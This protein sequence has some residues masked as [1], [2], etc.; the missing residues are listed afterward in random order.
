MSVSPIVMALRQAGTPAA[1]DPETWTRWLD[2]CQNEGLISPRTRNWLGV[3]GWLSRQVGEVPARSLSE[4]VRGQET[5]LRVVD[6]LAKQ[7]HTEHRHLVGSHEASTLIL[8]APLDLSGMKGLVLDQVC[9]V[10]GYRGWSTYLTP[11]QVAHAT[12]CH[13][14]QEY[15]PGQG[16]AIRPETYK[17]YG[18]DL[19]N[20]LIEIKLA[21]VKDAGGETVALVSSV[22]S[23]WCREGRLLGYTADWAPGHDRVPEAPMKNVHDWV[24]RAMKQAAVWAAERGAT[25]VAW[26]DGMQKCRLNLQAFEGCMLR[27]NRKDDQSFNYQVLRGD[28]WPLMHGQVQLG[29][30]LMKL[31]SVAAEKLRDAP[32]GES[33]YEDIEV[34]MQGDETN[35]VHDLVLPSVMR[36]WAASYDADLRAGEITVR[37]F[38]VVRTFDAKRERI[39]SHLDENEAC[40]RVHAHGSPEI[41]LEPANI[42]YRAYSFALTPSMKLAIEENYDVP[43]QPTDVRVVGMGR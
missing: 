29:H 38:D 19:P 26:I 20:A 25:R 16:P 37:S 5:P 34:S 28:G 7:S 6:L 40:Q 1:G 13:Q 43:D 32:L 31:G 23:P 8:M 10:L 22:D 21:L 3:D 14:A 27:I 33:S 2:A 30:A 4:F 17:P 9:K 24:L 41:T 12:A 39:S 42:S 35:F 36:G 18:S 15:G 11:E